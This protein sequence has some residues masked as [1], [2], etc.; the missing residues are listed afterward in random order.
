MS[1]SG[2]LTVARL[3]LLGPVAA[4]LA[5]CGGVRAAVADDGATRPPDI[6]IVVAGG[7]GQ[8]TAVPS[9]EERFAQLWELMKPSFNGTEPVPD[10][11]REGKHPPVRISVVWGLTGVGGWP[12]TGSIPGGD[13]AIERQD[14]LVV[15]EDGTPWVRSDPAPEV[16]DDDIR[17]HRASRSLYE[18]MDR[19]GLLGEPVR[20]MAPEADDPGPAPDTRWWAAGGL[21]VGLASGAGGTLA[22]RRAAARREA[23]PPREGPRQQLI[24][25]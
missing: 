5:L 18:R 13:V 8:P 12:M 16:E 21:A 19:A 22:I 1:G 17:W 11:W 4:A 24:D 25:L 23:G 14:E 10:A 20:G 15:A 9:G 3:A 7:A 2:R 6:A